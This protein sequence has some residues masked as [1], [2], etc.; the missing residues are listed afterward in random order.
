YVNGLQT[1]M[2]RVEVCSHS[3]YSSSSSAARVVKSD[4][5]N[6]YVV[7]DSATREDIANV[8]FQ[9]LTRFTHDANAKAG[10]IQHPLKLLAACGDSRR[11]HC[12]SLGSDLSCQR[13]VYCVVILFAP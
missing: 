13:S 9:Q 8:V 10:G 4:S 7:S 6:Q 2:R 11:L 12:G 1:Y 3:M 5:W